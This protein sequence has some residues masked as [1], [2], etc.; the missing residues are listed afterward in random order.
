MWWLYGDNSGGPFGGNAS[1]WKSCIMVYKVSPILVYYGL[2]VWIQEWV[3][4]YNDDLI[5]C[6][7]MVIT[8]DFG[9]LWF[10]GVD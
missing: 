1:Y 2:M 7:Y 6:Y 10:D 5:K 9:V 8:S 4:N 3:A